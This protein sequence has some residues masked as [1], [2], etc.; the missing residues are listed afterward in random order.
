MMT[1]D[2]FVAKCG[3]LQ[4]ASYT[5]RVPYVT[6]QRWRKG[7]TRPSRMVSELIEKVHGVTIP[8]CQR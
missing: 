1:L 5:L 6:L 4:Q 7:K 8:F 2:Q 3:N